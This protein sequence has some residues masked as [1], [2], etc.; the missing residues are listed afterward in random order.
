MAEHRAVT[1]PHIMRD[2]DIRHQ[3]IVVAD[4]GQHAAALGA[5]MNGH[6]LANAVAASD[7]R[8][9][10]LALVLQILWR[11]ANSAIGIKNIILAD[12]GGTFHINVGHQP[13]ACRNLNLRSNDAVRTYLRGIS[14]N[15]AGV[16][17]GCRMDG[18]YSGLS[19]SLHITSASATS[20]PSTVALPLILATEA[21]RFSIVSSMRN[22]SP[23]T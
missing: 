21:L 13:R 4:A 2:V 19:A 11:H 14:Y 12:R 15:C 23:G 16:D 18:H 22:W 8:F 10:C 17:K 9:R 20:A 5:A 6:E 7:A 1:H 3:Q